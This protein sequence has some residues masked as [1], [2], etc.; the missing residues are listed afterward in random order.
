MSIG[1]IQ[2]IQLTTGDPQIIEHEI[3]SNAEVF[4]EEVTASNLKIS[5]VV[6]F[7]GVMAGN[8]GKPPTYVDRDRVFLALRKGETCEAETEREEESDPV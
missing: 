1:L 7:V 8:C 4:I 6:Q 3:S 2:E 5:S